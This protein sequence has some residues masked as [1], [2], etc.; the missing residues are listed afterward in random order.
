M[1]YTI[2]ELSTEF[3]VSTKYIKRIVENQ[4]QP[5]NR[6]EYTWTPTNI[7]E[8]LSGGCGRSFDSSGFMAH[9]ETYTSGGLRELV[10]AALMPG[11][12]SSHPRI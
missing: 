1:N 3:G 8:V 11:T 12:F 6:T 9:M 7:C 10:C 5:A 2:R 4:I